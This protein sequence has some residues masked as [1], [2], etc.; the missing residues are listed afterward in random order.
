MGRGDPCRPGRELTEGRELVLRHADDL[1]E[2]QRHDLVATALGE[3]GL[4]PRCE[5]G[6]IYGVGHHHRRLVE[7]ESTEVRGAPGRIERDV[8]T[9]GVAQEVDRPA[10][11]VG[12]GVDDGDHVLD[13][14]PEVIVLRISA[15]APAP[16]I[17]GAQRGVVLE[18]SPHRLPTGVV[19]RRSVAP[20]RA[21]DQVPLRQKA[22]GVPSAREH[23]VHHL[24]RRHDRTSSVAGRSVIRTALPRLWRS[25]LRETFRNLS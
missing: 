11:L 18:Q 16:S 3:Q 21:D 7:R 6:G 9:V 13:L 20:A 10:P 1:A 2:E 25:A 15:L 8:R 14:E 5:P 23:L 17:D 19:G 12:D 24:F 4:D 22:I